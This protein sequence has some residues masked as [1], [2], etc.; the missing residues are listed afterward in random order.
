VVVYDPAAMDSTRSVLGD[1]LVYAASAAECAGQAD[2][3]A[4]VTPWPEFRNLGPADLKKG[5]TPAIVD[6]WRVL[7][8]ADFEPVSEYMTLGYGMNSLVQSAKAD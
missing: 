6:C 8:R 2:V 1:R 4:I 7:P 3:L 5:V